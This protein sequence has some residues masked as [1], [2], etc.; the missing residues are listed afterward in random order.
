MQQ[1]SVPAWAPKWTE[2]R[3]RASVGRCFSIHPSAPKK[4]KTSKS[5]QSK[6][7]S[8]RNLVSGLSN[9]LSVSS[10]GALHFS[11]GWPLVSFFGLLCIR[12]DR[13]I[14]SGSSTSTSNF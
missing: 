9:P 14:R 6:K 1:V 2:Q 12:F 11:L 8:Q 7:Q 3:V 10:G 4:N 13:D 5:V